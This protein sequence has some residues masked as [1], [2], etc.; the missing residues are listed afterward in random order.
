[1]IPELGSSVFAFEALGMMD[2]ARIAALEILELTK[3]QSAT[4]LVPVSLSFSLL[5]SRS[6][7]GLEAE[8]R[9]LVEQASPGR[10]KDIAFATLDRDFSRAADLWLDSGSPTWEA[11]LRE[12]AAAELIEAGRRAEG[13][14]ELGKALAFYRS[15][16][17]TFFLER[18]EALLDEARSA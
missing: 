2:E 11:Y 9:E 18:G 5:W 1:M 10:W 8:L 3:A 17:A 14:A 6:A 15:V 16:R 7:A 4:S 13:E 12:R